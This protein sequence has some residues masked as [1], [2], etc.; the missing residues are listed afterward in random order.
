MRLNIQLVYTATVLLLIGS[1]SGFI[2]PLKQNRI[3][4]SHHSTKHQILKVRGGDTSSTSS[5]TTALQMHLGPILKEALVSGNSLQG[6][7]ALYALTS[8]TVVPLTWY[9]TG[10]SF[11]VGYGFSIAVMA[12]SIL[13]SFGYAD[14]IKN[15]DVA[16]L[17]I[18]SILAVT[19]LLYGIRL[20]LYIFV[21]EKTVETKKK[22]FAEMD[23]SPWYKRTP[24]ALSVSILYAFLMTPVLVAM[25]TP[26]ES[27]SVLQKV[28]KIFTGMAACGMVLEAVADQH[29]YEAKR[30][31]LKDTDKFVGPTNWTYK[32]CRHP[33]YLGEI[34]HWTGIFGAGAV[35][36]GKDIVAWLASALGLVGILSIMFGA[37]A[38]L[39]KKQAEKYEGQPKYDAWKG[40]VTSS[41][42]PFI[43]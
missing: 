20:G 36:F 8:L 12:A 27:G 25:K 34:M 41:V 11:S 16:S 4:K 5:S 32:L 37:S 17:S 22:Q 14:G 31:G 23:K 26:V 29:K 9:R 35:V 40:E 42:I 7:G 30:N 6:V 2:S 24:L 15:L 1:V 39:D 28:Q 18:P 38:R 10:Y 13:T 43:K 3:L 19:A 33:N 21:R